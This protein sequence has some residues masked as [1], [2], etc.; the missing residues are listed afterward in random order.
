[1]GTLWAAIFAHQFSMGDE[2]IAGMIIDYVIIVGVQ[3]L[4]IYTT[5]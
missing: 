3:I 5:G 2:Y 4:V 1:M